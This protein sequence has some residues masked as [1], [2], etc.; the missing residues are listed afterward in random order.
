MICITHTQARGHTTHTHTP[1]L[2]LIA[3][4]S[5]PVAIDSE[6]GP[7]P[8]QGRQRMLFSPRAQQ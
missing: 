2:C 4:F 7:G 1:K 6:I 3:E 5:P 8:K